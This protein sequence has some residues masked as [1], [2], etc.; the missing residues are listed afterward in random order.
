[1]TM[2]LIGSALFWIS[3]LGFNIGN[4]H[5]VQSNS[6]TASSG[7]ETIKRMVGNEQVWSENI[8]REYAD[9]FPNEFAESRLIIP[10]YND[11][12]VGQKH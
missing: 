6:Q 3:G 4:A 7:L 8:Q 5:S 1:M 12:F 2:M 9:L 10:S 11:N